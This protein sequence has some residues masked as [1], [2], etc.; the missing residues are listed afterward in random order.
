MAARHGRDTVAPGLLAGYAAVAIV[1]VQGESIGCGGG[2]A[3]RCGAAL[4]PLSV[5][6]IRRLGEALARHEA[7]HP[8]AVAIIQLLLFT[9]CRKSEIV[10]L[11]WRFRG[12]YASTDASHRRKRLCAG[13]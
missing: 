9:G 11:K 12:G 6:E 5:A 8:Q 2:V 10:T 13:C 3:L 1:V 4:D 7:D